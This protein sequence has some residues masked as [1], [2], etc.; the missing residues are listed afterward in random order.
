M[1]RT[2]SY[3]EVMRFELARTL[4]GRGR[5][6]TAAYLVDG[7]LVD[8]G[9]AHS[10]GELVNALAK[11]PLVGIVNTHSHED[12]I[13]ANALMQRRRDGLPIR[14]HPLAL[15]VMAHPRGRLS[16]HAY[17]Q[18]LYPGAFL[19]PGPSPLVPEGENGGV[20]HV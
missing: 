6:W 7:L 13:G 18:V 11:A 19:T 3:G 2:T 1:L 10:A 15:P 16:L 17:Q 5:Y 14:A 20:S 8:T 4:L 12:H 9:C